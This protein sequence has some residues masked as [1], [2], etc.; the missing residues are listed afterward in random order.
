MVSFDPSP[1]QNALPAGQNF[2]PSHAHVLHLRHMRRKVNIP[3]YLFM[4]VP[5]RWN[6]HRSMHACVYVCMC[7]CLYVCM[8]MYMYVY[9]CV[10][11][12]MYVYVCVCM[13]VYVCMYVRTYVSTCVYIY[14]IIYNIVYI[15]CINIYGNPGENKI[16]NCELS[17]KLAKMRLCLKNPNRIYFW[18][19]IHIGTSYIN[20]YY[21]YTFIL[22]TVYI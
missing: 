10:C 19:I 18:M 3:I 12:C 22:Y 15:I 1:Y 14:I 7:V 2:D 6:L 20:W 8:Y 16:W 5:P 4:V 21:I 11:M 9:V 13:Y 17:R